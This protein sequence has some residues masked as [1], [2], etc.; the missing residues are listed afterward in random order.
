M[1]RGSELSHLVDAL[2]CGRRVKVEQRV[3]SGKNISHWE[4]HK[5]SQRLPK[6]PN[7]TILPKTN[8]ERLV[9]NHS[10]NECQRSLKDSQW[11]FKDCQ[12]NLKACPKILKGLPKI[13]KD[14][15]R[16]L[17]DSQRSPKDSQRSP[18][19][20]PMILNDLLDIL[21]LLYILQFKQL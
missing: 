9:S 5:D 4:T 7:D 11:T 19:D 17:K 14:S 20:V 15:Q 2:S 8:W 13:L 21:N 18:K 3:T 1:H 12:S 10:P 16:S 6:T